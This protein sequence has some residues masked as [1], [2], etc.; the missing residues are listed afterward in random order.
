[1][2]VICDVEAD[3]LKKPRNIWVISCI[4]V[5]TG[6]EHVF[7]YPIDRTAFRRWASGV[8]LWIGHNFLGY[9]LWVV[10]RLLGYQIDP[11]AVLDTLVL[12]RLLYYSIPGGHSLAAWGDRL[13]YPKDTFNDFSKYSLELE[14]RCTQDTKINY[15]FWSYLQK[16]LNDTKL[17]QSILIEHYMYIIC[18]DIHENGFK[19]DYD[20]AKELYHSLSSQVE[21]LDHDLQEVFPP[22]AKLVRTINP[23]ATRHGTLH[24]QDF[25][26]LGGDAVID[27]FAPGCPFSL[28]EW[29]TFNPGSPSQIVERLNSAGWKPYEKTKSGKSF[30][31][32]ENNLETL[33]D[34]APEASRRL[35]KRLMLASRVRR[36]EEW[37]KAYE[38]S[39]GR[40]HGNINHIGTWTHRCNHTNP[41]M[42]NVPSLYSK[43]TSDELKE[44]AHELGIEMR[45]LWTV[46]EDRVLVGC[47]ADGIQLRVF[48][49]YVNDDEFTKA[50]VSGDS[51]NGT[52]A[53]SL[54]AKIL[55]STRSQAKTFIYA[56]LLNCGVAKTALI[57]GCDMD[58]AAYKRSKFIA[59]YPGLEYVREELIPRDIERGYFEGFDGRKVIIP[60]TEGNMLGYVLGGY[61]QNGETC[62]MKHANVNW[63]MKLRKEDVPF[64]QVNFIHDEWQTETYEQYAKYIGEVQSQ[65]I[66][67]IGV[68]FGLHCPLGG[69]YKIG[70]NWY[71]T[72]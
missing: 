69:N 57:F 65:S 21:E 20:R 38:P 45:S 30:K 70:R 13:G 19:F 71:E 5:D 11:L 29:E 32:S 67:D 58:E 44:I 27:G 26:W 55:E 66:V 37:F 35:V 60:K 25:R 59:K 6:E 18:N 34:S 47:D 41:N 48:A 14:K 50:L 12:S 31:V 23:R 22:K 62:I 33:P 7:R 4:D 54:N 2:R 40:I 64:W 15:S 49:H 52:D 42:G 36:L 39:T 68:Q 61:L 46:P 10:G 8:T 17:S 56:F 16:Y 53:H 51:K 43:Y 24:K 63:R 1:M 28:V 9:D 3:D 72:H